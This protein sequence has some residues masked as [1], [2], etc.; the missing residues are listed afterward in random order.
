M[1]LHCPHCGIEGSADDV[2]AGCRIRCSTCQ[3]EF[4]AKENSPDQDGSHETFGPKLT[5]ACPH[6][7]VTG[8]ADISF[9]GC[10]V[11]CPACKE[12]F[13]VHTGGEDTVEGLPLAHPKLEAPPL[14][15]F[16]TREVL[17]KTMADTALDSAAK[18]SSLPAVNLVLQAEDTLEQEVDE[19][20]ADGLEPGA[21]ARVESS[22]DEPVEDQG[23]AEDLVLEKEQETLEAMAEEGEAAALDAVEESMEKEGVEELGEVQIS[24]SADGEEN[25]DGKDSGTAEDEVATALLPSA[26]DPWL[27]E[28]LQ[29]QKEAM[30]D[31]A[32]E[33]EPVLTEEVFENAADVGDVG[34]VGEN[35]ADKKSYGTSL[36]PKEDRQEK[37]QEEPDYGQQQQTIQT[38]PDGLDAAEAAALAA[39]LAPAEAAEK[40]E[41]EPS[42]KDGPKG[43]QS[44]DNSLKGML[45]EAWL[46]TKGAKA[47][48]WKATA[49]MFLLGLVVIAGQEVFFPAPEE[50]S[51]YPY[52]V[53]TIIQFFTEVVSVIFS[54]GLIYMGVL[55]ARGEEVAW[56]MV[57]EGFRRSWVRILLV[58]LLQTMVLFIGFFL[59]IIPFIYLSVGYALTLPL[60]VLHGMSP[61]EAMET[62]RKAIHPIW[63]KVFGLY[64]VMLVVTLIATLPLGLGLIWI[65]PMYFILLGV[66]YRNLFGDAE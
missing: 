14:E 46:K 17:T 58:V 62:S 44:F 23:L 8:S 49:I 7:G 15:E 38:D 22:Q 5:L 53:F 51:F 34:D 3:Q 65:W 57:F 42:S 1:K 25:R 52:L 20:L 39:G 6:C 27:E 9:S 50:L 45:E 40:E 36:P 16:L 43:E 55:R 32:L 10:R 4:I 59:F 37:E 2:Y 56:Q 12:L 64:L 26:E 33:E 11:Q 24:L 13:V 19:Q 21:A 28:E 35:A 61:W 30:Q 31:L 66:L 47:S 29:D 60:V 18:E 54:A 41:L 63:W 48:F